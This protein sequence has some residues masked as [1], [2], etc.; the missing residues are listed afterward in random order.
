MAE[1]D[2]PTGSRSVFDGVVLHLEI[3]DWPGLPPHEVVHH[4]GASAILALLP[5]DDVILVK[6]FRPAVRRSLT[7]DPRPACWMS[8]GRM[9]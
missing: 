3:E 7:E 4:P 2:Q 1:L 8:M 9:P 5:S 6:Q